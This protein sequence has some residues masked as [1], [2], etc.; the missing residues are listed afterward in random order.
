MP[1]CEESKISEEG[2][3]LQSLELKATRSLYLP[4]AIPEKV[5]WKVTL[6]ASNAE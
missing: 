3:E 5:G 1:C 6:T 4:A 2:E